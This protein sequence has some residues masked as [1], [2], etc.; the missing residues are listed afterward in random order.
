MKTSHDY[1]DI[2]I[3]PL[4]PLELHCNRCQTKTRQ[5]KSDK[6]K[7]KAE[8]KEFRPKKT[9]GAIALAEIKEIAIHDDSDNN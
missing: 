1:L 6:K 5:H 9:A 2:P 7:L 4:Y 3:Q 8:A